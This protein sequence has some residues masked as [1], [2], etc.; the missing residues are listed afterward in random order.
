MLT[1]SAKSAFEVLFLF[2]EG[3]NRS[4]LNSLKKFKVY[5]SEKEQYQPL[6]WITGKD[7]ENAN[8]IQVLELL[9][10]TVE[11]LL[12]EEEAETPKKITD[13]QLGNLN[14]TTRYS[15]QLSQSAKKN[16]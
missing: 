2:F 8:L 12:E 13:S 9:E 15:T 16:L 5:Y 3:K 14:L 7:K 11:A 6:N 4:S 10:A 1:L